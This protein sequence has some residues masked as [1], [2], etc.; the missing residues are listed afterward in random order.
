VFLGGPFYQR[1]FEEHGL[2]Q[3][4]QIGGSFGVALAASPETSLR[5]VLDET[6]VRDTESHRTVLGG[7]EQNIGVLTL[8][9][10]TTL[11]VGVFLDFAIQAGLTHDAPALGA[12]VSFSMRFHL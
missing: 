11:H 9:A 7:T 5:V 10:S 4:D 2:R 8:G 6:F 3:G 12:G 1:S